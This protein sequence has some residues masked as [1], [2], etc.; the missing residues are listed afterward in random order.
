MDLLQIK[1][2]DRSIH[3]V[4]VLYYIQFVERNIFGSHILI[5]CWHTLLE[6][7]FNN[8]HL[9]N[10]KWLIGVIYLNSTLLH[11]L[12]N[13]FQSSD[14]WPKMHYINPSQNSM[15]DKRWSPQQAMSVFLLDNENEIIQSICLGVSAAKQQAFFA[16]TVYIGEDP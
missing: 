13:I 1:K 15:S 3:W 16:V 14:T 8:T 2:M 12:E 10:Q 5:P 11:L 7:I 6:L 4:L 9:T